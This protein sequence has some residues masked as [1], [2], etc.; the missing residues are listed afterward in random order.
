MTLYVDYLDDYRETLYLSN[1]LDLGDD[2]FQEIA[3]DV[4]PAYDWD[5][6]AWDD[7]EVKMLATIAAVERFGE[8]VEIEW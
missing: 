5:S 7:D 4:S 1:G 8:D 6:E 2:D 3:V